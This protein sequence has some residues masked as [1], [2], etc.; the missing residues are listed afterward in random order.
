MLLL[1]LIVRVATRRAWQAIAGSFVL[2]TALS[3]LTAGY[4]VAFPWVT[5]SIVCMIAIG[6][7]MRAGL[8]A[9][10]AAAFFSSLILASPITANTG[11]WYAP[12]SVF[13]TAVAATVLVYAFYLERSGGHS[14]R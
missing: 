10:I 1:V 2:L 3:A 11:A 6:L 7:L 5:S 8:V 9:L 4:D 12:A 13:A 14:I